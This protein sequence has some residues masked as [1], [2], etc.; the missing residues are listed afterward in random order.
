MEDK[1]F[2]LKAL[3]ID[4]IAIAVMFGVLEVLKAIA[5]RM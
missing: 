4:A 3:I 1:K 5:E 2:V